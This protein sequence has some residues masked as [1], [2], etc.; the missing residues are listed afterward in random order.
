MRRK[1]G[2]ALV[3]GGGGCL[4]YTS[5]FSSVYTAG[6]YSNAVNLTSD[7]FSFVE[8]NKVNNRYILR[9]FQVE[10]GVFTYIL[11]TGEKYWFFFN[12]WRF[13]IYVFYNDR[14][15]SSCLL[16]TSRCV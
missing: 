3:G 5:H 12:F 13:L 8:N 6:Q 4:L 7:S 15:I 11:S 2:G 9:M 16:Y 14:C 1:G 10:P